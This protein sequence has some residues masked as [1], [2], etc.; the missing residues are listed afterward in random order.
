MSILDKVSKKVIFRCAL[1]LLILPSID[2]L[3]SSDR[4]AVK[5]TVVRDRVFPEKGGE[6][7]GF[8][9]TRDESCRR[10]HS[11]PLYCLCQK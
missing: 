4:V 3:L 5:E 7:D 2:T 8:D 1:P 6:K 11:L 9:K 10:I